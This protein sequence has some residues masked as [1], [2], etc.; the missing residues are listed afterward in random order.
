[1]RCPL[2]PA[3]GLLSLL[4]PNQAKEQDRHVHER[5]QSVL[6]I[7][8][9]GSFEPFGALNALSYDGYA[10][11]EHPAFADHRVRVKKSRLCDGSVDAYTGYIDVHVKHIYFWFFES[12]NDPDTDDVVLW[13]NG[14][15][16][17][18]SSVGLFAELGPCRV[19]SPNATEY[20]EYSWNSVANVIFIDQPVGSGWSYADHGKYVETSKEASADIAAFLVI[21]FENFS[22]FQGRAFHLA[23]ESYAGR[24]MPVFGSVIY[25]MN[26]KLVE[27]GLTPIN[28][29]SIMLGNGLTD[30][31]ESTI[32]RYDMMCTSVSV[33][34]V[35]PISTCVRMTQ[36]VPRCRQWTKAACIDQ[37]DAMSCTAALN[38]C[39][40]SITEMIRSTDVNGYDLSRKCEG[41]YE[42]TGCYYSHKDV[43]GYLSRPDVQEAMGVDPARR[44]PYAPC[45]YAIQSAF[46]AAMDRNQPTHLHV[47]ALL[48]RGIRVLVY[49]GTNDMLCSWVGNDR[50]TRAMEW[51][52]KEAL[53]N[54]EPREWTVDGVIAG[55]AR[56]SRGLTVA[57]IYGAGHYAPQDKPQEA[58]AL[59]ERWLKGLAL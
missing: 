34:P 53:A 12:R 8:K 57:T 41:K 30:I 45:D 43:R 28:L 26:S 21:F 16:G 19:I 52:G 54:A 20:N 44:G 36:A 39:D 4:S 58:L 55:Q 1:M 6:Q 2:W 35:L 7:L 59:A 33:P 9:H 42:E 27:A 38:F 50:W 11:L 10:S 48:E 51:S 13:G 14:G 18:S 5:G 23:G 37:L 22:K 46:H 15:P 49:A 24:M 29:T 56:N 17:C 31:Y 3:L 32:A 25:D 47:A 40:D